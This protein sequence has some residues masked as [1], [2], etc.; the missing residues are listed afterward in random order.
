MQKFDHCHSDVRIEDNVQKEE[1]I[2]E[3]KQHKIC[4]VT[5]PSSQLI[6]NTCPAKMNQ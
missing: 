4:N 5:C 2:I 6:P 3:I 1:F